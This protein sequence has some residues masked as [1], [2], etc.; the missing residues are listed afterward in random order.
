MRAQQGSGSAR[1][2]MNN[3][4]NNNN[5]SK[6]RIFRGV[7][8]RLNSSAEDSDSFS[9]SDDG[10]DQA[11]QGSQN[12]SQNRTNG[13]GTSSRNES[14]P[15]GNSALS[16]SKSSGGPP[17]ATAL[18]S[19]ERTNTTTESP[20]RVLGFSYNNTQ[21]TNP[22]M[23]PS[24]K[25]KRPTFQNDSSEDDFGGAD[26]ADSETERQLSAI[27]DESARKQRQSQ[28]QQLAKSMNGMAAAAVDDIDHNGGLPTPRTNRN[29]LRLLHEE[30]E[31]HSKKRQRTV[32]FAPLPQ[33]EQTS[34][35]D[36][37]LESGVDVETPTPYRKRDALA[38]H[39]ITPEPK[40]LKHHPQT[41]STSFTTPN[42]GVSTPSSIN[43]KPTVYP[44]IANKIVAHLINVPISE[45]TRRNIDAD[46]TQYENQVK[47]IA[48]GRDL[49]R[50]KWQD[51]QA[52]YGGLQAQNAQLQD[53]VAHLENQLAM[54]RR[55]MGEKLRNLSEQFLDY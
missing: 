43:N 33:D 15:L 12:R 21:P 39:N 37:D 49:L 47:G 51:A 46:L 55:S 14:Q 23:T 10:D 44:K 13:N 29:S 8:A 7:P 9:M 42:G 40:T 45:K 53:R 1:K 34:E 54:T 2:N 30:R 11:H 19:Q 4:N 3:N 27:V 28:A 25:R 6:Q 24:A 50:E 41:P 36:E 35:D 32:E 38:A 31:R 26:L 20:S 22:P 5:N 17:R 18:S 16:A 52:Q 48:K